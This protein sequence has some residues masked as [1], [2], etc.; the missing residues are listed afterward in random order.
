MKL[1]PFRLIVLRAFNVTL[2]RSATLDALLRKV[3]V[4]VLVHGAKT[5]YVQ[6]SRFFTPD[7]LD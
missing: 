1:T 2:G 5:P 4:R 6:S 7:Q 3:L